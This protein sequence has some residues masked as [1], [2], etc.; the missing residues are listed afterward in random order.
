MVRLG[1]FAHESPVPDKKTPW[2]RARLAGFEGRGTGEN[3]FMGSTS[4]QAAYD[5]WF[6]SDGHRFIMMAN[7]PTLL[8]VGIAGNHWT[9][10]TG[11]R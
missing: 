8:G 7:G 3:I 11:K 5:A 2:D 6:A 10:M 9:M 4:P 1:F